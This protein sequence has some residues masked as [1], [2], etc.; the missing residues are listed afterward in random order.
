MADLQKLKAQILA[1]GSI[2]DDDVDLI[3]RELYPDATFN[4]NQVEFLIALRNEARW[5]C[6]TFE[7][8]VFEAVK[9]HVLMDGAIDEEEADWLRQALLAG[10]E[11]DEREWKFLCEL[12][13]EAIS[14]SPAFRELYDDCVEGR[15][16]AGDEAP[17]EETAG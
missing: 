16:V 10:G 2:R 1:H 7:D 17:S 12:K 3:C 13:R 8:L 4:R 14:V 9:F 15:A 5:V 6:T 11:A